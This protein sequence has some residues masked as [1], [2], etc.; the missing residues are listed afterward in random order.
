MSRMKMRR[1]LVRVGFLAFVVVATL[2]IAV[3]NCMAGQFFKPGGYQECVNKSGGRAHIWSV[4]NYACV[5]AT[6]KSQNACASW[7]G[8]ANSSTSTAVVASSLTGTVRVKIWGMC[9]DRENTSSA[10]NIM[11]DGGSVTCDRGNC[12]F[13]RSGKWGSP[14]SKDATL[15][16]AKFINGATLT[17]YNGQRAYY[18]MIIVDRMHG[19]NTSMGVDFSPI[20]LVVGEEEET[21]PPPPLDTCESVGNPGSY[22]SSGEFSGTTSV[23]I[24]IR[25][26]ASRFGDEGE[27]AWHAIKKYGR[28]GSDV[29]Y[30][31]PTDKIAWHTCYWPGVQTTAETEVSSVTGYG[32][33]WKGYEELSDSVC[34]ADKDVEYRLLKDVATPWRNAFTLS[35]AADSGDIGKQGD[36]GAGNKEV[37]EADSYKTTH[38]GDAGET[39]TE[40]AVSEHPISAN[41]KR[42]NPTTNVY[43]CPCCPNPPEQKCEGEGE[44]QKCEDVPCDETNDCYCCTNRYAREIR[45]ATVTTDP[46]SDYASVL[47]PHNFYNVPRV[48]LEKNFTY[49]GETIGV[50]NVTV[51]VQR[52]YNGVT[53]D[54]YA[55]EVPNAEIKLF[56]Y[57]SGSSGGSFGDQVPNADCSVLQSKTKHNQ[58]KQ[59]GSATKS[60]NSGGSLLD[61]ADSIEELVKEY[62]SYDV[63]AGDYMCFVAAVYP[64]QSDGYK[65]IAGN[66][67]GMWRFSQPA[68]AIVAK[69]PTFQVW[70]GDMYTNSTINAITAEK[71][72]VY[73][74]YKN[75]MD[76]FTRWG[77][78]STYYG[79]WAEEGLVIGTSG[80][81]ST[82]GNFAFASGAALGYNIDDGKAR[83]GRSNLNCSEIAP[84]TIANS[85]GSCGDPSGIG[86]EFKNNN[87]NRRELID[88]W[89]KSTQNPT[90]SGAKI[91]YSND[92]SVGNKTAYKK[93]TWIYD[94]N[95]TFTIT[96]NIKYEDGYNASSTLRDIPKVII[97]ASN[98]N[99][100]C[101]VT[102]VDAIIITKT[103]GMVKT[104]SNA[105]GDDSHSSRGNPLKIFGMVITDSIELGRTYGSAAWSGS[106]PNGQQAAAEVF[107]FDSSILLW[108]EFM[109]SAAET[110]TM[111]VVYQNEIAPRY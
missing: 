84:L 58:C 89:G 40:D 36:Y 29:I 17:T 65:D 96:G 97:Y 67:N 56:A 11:S 103:G 99:I 107:D 52:I 93:E 61:T 57:A 1:G 33:E 49:A 15:D 104:C 92:N 34:E 75:N 6:E 74:Y 42:T 16:V 73:N 20:Y 48:A 78:T 66:G 106:G 7:L 76:N 39:F 43:K 79:S 23:D 41:I 5:K 4:A 109:A 101:N 77:G 30:A 38:E 32:E 35:G 45:D 31:K 60:L 63:S 80:G 47:I 13:T 68:C 64:A 85:G 8:S 95:G 25:N 21:P 3:Q 108:S 111:Q 10:M 82:G 12:N 53:K 81:I 59:F 2:N 86:S 102:E 26:T 27:G 70:G 91:I 98:V 55:T 87:D 22:D 28:D 19:G 100:Q 14:S 37:R 46:D 71:R 24:W 94:V 110:D 9:T 69:R 51:L 90:A 50:D 62:N 54:T 72:N 83:T 18:R 105:G 88:Y 44:E